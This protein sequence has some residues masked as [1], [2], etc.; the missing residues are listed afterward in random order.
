MEMEKLKE[1]LHKHNAN[2]IK[3]INKRIK[4]LAMFCIFNFIIVF[5]CIV[6]IMILLKC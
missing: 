1:V 5:F 6:G 3:E 2:I 4:P